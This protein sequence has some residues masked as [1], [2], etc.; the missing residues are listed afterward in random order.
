MWLSNTVEQAATE[1]A[2]YAAVRGSSKAAVATTQAITDF[3]KGQAELI[4][5]SDMN[6]EESC[7]PP[8]DNTPASTVT[9]RVTYNFEC[10]L[11]G[12]LGFD[13]VDLEGTSTLVID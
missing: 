9:I 12:F 10:L 7:T 2:R 3:M 13:P 6:I 11:V 5:P 8:N 4:P 1:G